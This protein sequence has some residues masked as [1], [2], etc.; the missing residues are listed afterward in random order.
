M[1]ITDYIKN[2]IHAKAK[3]LKEHLYCPVSDKAALESVLQDFRTKD[4]YFAVDEMCG[5][6]NQEHNGRTKEIIPIVIMILEKLDKPNDMQERE[7]ATQR[8]RVIKDKIIAKLRYDNEGKK[9]KQYFSAIENNIPFD[10]LAAGELIPHLAGVYMTIGFHVPK[11][12]EY[13]PEDYE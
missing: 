8:A 11:M 1:K 5:G 10:E 12:L 2:E 13:D 4:L 9:F 6:D 3:Y 7:T